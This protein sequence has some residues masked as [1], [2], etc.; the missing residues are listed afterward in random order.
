MRQ[1]GIHY[2]T[3]QFLADAFGLGASQN[4]KLVLCFQKAFP[5]PFS[6]TH[7]K[8]AHPWL[9]RALLPAIAE[10]EP[11]C[12]EWWV[13]IVSHRR[14]ILRLD[15][16]RWLVSDADAGFSTMCGNLYWGRKVGWN[17]DS[18]WFSSFADPSGTKHRFAAKPRHPC[19]GRLRSELDVRPVAKIISCSN[20][21]RFADRPDKPLIPG[22]HSILFQLVVPQE[23]NGATS[24]MTNW[25]RS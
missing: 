17:D 19:R 9:I 2:Y 5:P 14:V 18:D 4:F 1:P 22:D 10:F 15:Q 6:A 21:V 8:T 20:V 13:Y 25:R 11:D 16:A 23:R 24:F 7:Y 12:T 3:P